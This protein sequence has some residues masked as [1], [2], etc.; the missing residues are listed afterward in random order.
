MSASSEPM[1]I[2]FSIFQNQ[3]KIKSKLKVGQLNPS[4]RPKKE[5]KLWQIQA[6]EVRARIKGEASGLDLIRRIMEL[7]FRTR[8]HVQ[9]PMAA[10]LA[11]DW[12]MEGEREMMVAGLGSDG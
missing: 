12:V 9:G 1:K 7:G 2:I 8:Q 5:Q 3:K 10:H 6:E 11:L 4:Q